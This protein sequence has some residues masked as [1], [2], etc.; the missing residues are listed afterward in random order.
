M[1]TW[2]WDSSAPGAEG[3]GVSDA[4]DAAKA[5]AEAWMRQHAAAAAVAAP[6]RLDVVDLAYVPAGRPLEAVRHGNN[7]ITWRPAAA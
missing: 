5:A 1:T 7:Q 3:C 2:I 6:V 4:E